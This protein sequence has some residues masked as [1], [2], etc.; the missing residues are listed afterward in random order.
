MS[1]LSPLEIATR[2]VLGLNTTVGK[3]FGADM[4]ASAVRQLGQIGEVNPDLRD[5]FLTALADAMQ[6]KDTFYR[7]DVVRG[8]RG[9]PGKGGLVATDRAFAIAQEVL[10]R[11]DKGKLGPAAETQADV[12]AELAERFGI[13]IPTVRDELKDGRKAHAT[14]REKLLKRRGP[15][16]S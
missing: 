9:Q 15:A 1:K 5:K 13:S 3:P 6:D 8:R 11:C 14:R 2:V 12:C 7:I 16:N 4:L 10:E